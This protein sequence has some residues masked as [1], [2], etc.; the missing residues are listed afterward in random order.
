MRVSIQHR[1]RR[2]GFL[3]N[4]RQVEVVTSVQ[5]SEEEKSI[6]WRRQLGDF[7]VIA[8]HPNSHQAKRREL[9][10]PRPRT[11]DFDLLVS[12]LMKG[13]PDTFACDTPVHA[14][15]YERALVEALKELKSFIVHGAALGP[16]TSFGF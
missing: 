9:W 11:D 8:R 13:R 7:I 2:A 14:K 12:S 1:E 15:A 16:P 5:F 6:I 4:V 3:R 10:N